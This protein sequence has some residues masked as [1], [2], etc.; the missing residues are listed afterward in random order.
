MFR[1][2]HDKQSIIEQL[3]EYQIVIV[4]GIV[5]S[6]YA[7]IERS[8]KHLARQLSRFKFCDVKSEMGAVI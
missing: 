7:E 1:P 5:L 2:G 6:T 4:A 3:V 8:S